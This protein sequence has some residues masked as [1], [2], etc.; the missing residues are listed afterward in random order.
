MPDREAEHP[1]CLDMDCS[2]PNGLLLS[3][4]ILYSFGLSLNVFSE[5]KV[6]GESESKSECEVKVV[7]FYVTMFV[8]HT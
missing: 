3:Q 4:L 8:S 6:G 7:L 5:S 1:T 2:L